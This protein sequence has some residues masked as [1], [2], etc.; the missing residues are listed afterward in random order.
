[1][2][3]NLP[4]LVI[5]YSLTDFE[6]NAHIFSDVKHA[7]KFAKACNYLQYSGLRFFLYT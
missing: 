2:L 4:R 3:K 6:E 1:M 7:E 5:I